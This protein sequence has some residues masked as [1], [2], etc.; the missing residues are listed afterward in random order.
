MNSR[1]L[2]LEA[3]GRLSR[4]ST[5]WA[6]ATQAAA[7][8]HGLDAALPLIRSGALAGRR[9]GS[10]NRIDW[11]AASEAGEFSRVLQKLNDFFELF[12]RFVTTSYI[13]KCNFGM[14]FG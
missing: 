12:F 8:L 13:A 5:V 2:C 7:E 14:P 1:G 6:T 3:A 9:S 11:D 10:V 4:A